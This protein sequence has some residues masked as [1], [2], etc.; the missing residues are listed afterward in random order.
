MQGS[1]IIEVIKKYPAISINF[2][3]IFSIDNLPKDIPT[4][5]FIIFNED[6]AENK[7]IH[8]LALIKPK[9]NCLECF[10][11]LGLDTRKQDL[12]LKYHRFK[13]VKQIKF[14]ETRFQPL[15]SDKCGLFTLYFCINRLMNLDLSFRKF[16]EDFFSN[17]DKENEI[18]V[19]AF[20]NNGVEL[21]I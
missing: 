20:F 1:D 16:L 11:S 19:K 12:I 3:G 2:K 18:N 14:N 8:W 21:E 9:N 7:G 5:H 10:D 6:L 17:E 13:N 4:K 15:T